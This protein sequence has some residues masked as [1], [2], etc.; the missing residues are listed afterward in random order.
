[1]EETEPRLPSDTC[2][3]AADHPEWSLIPLQENLALVD[4]Q[5]KGAI[6]TIKKSSRTASSS[7]YVS[8][9]SLLTPHPDP[10][11]SAQ[12]RDVFSKRK[13][14][15]GLLQLRRGRAHTNIHTQSD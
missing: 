10:H 9:S 3:N 7:E 2:L 14:N 4:Q 6:H 12:R 13:R 5:K 1:M 15:E 8:S 11:S